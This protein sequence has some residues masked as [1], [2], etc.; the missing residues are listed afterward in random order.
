LRGFLLQID[1]AEVALHE[2]DEPNAVVGS[3]GFLNVMD[4]EK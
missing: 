3:A 1:A 2:A 4:F